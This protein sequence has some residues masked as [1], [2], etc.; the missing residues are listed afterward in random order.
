MKEII[1][2]NVAAVDPLHQI[3]F[4]IYYKS[5]K[6]SHLVLKNNL[7]PP[8]ALLQRSHLIYQYQCH[9]EGCEPHSTYIGM[10]ATKLSR[11]LTCHLQNGAPKQHQVTRHNTPL[12]R[13]QL[14]DGTKILAYEND[15]RRL[16]ILEALFIK[17]HSPSM[18]LQSH[19]L[20]TLPSARA[21][22]PP[23]QR[24][25]PTDDVTTLSSNPS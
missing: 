16:A 21:M 9:N 12:T 17:E 23:A 1:K 3:S 7:N 11:R 20:L 15:A 25:P 13:K 8:P 14:E 6:T 5:R 24:G 18:N 10:T 4:I 2:K 19:D 22:L